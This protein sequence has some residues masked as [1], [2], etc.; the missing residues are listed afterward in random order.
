MKLKNLALIVIA[1]FV[2][3][4]CE[5]QMGSIKKEKIKGDEIF[6][7]EI[8]KA[9]PGAETL[10]GE[11]LDLG[12]KFNPEED[13]FGPE[14]TSVWVIGIGSDV[15]VY[16]AQVIIKLCNKYANGNIHVVVSKKENFD[17][18]NR[19]YIG[20]LYPYEDVK[21][22]DPNTVKMFMDKNLTQEQFKAMA[23]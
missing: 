8:N 14:A 5:S 12:Y 23:Q 4:S 11:L 2:L 16:T 3:F 15:D 6:R 19:I 20:S 1:A 7:L 13:W 17:D 9:F 18:K 22:I 21:P 10:A